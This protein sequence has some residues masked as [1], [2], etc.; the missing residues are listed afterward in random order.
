MEFLA[1]LPR[2]PDG[3]VARWRLRKKLV[4]VFTPP[5]GMSPP[6]GITPERL[7]RFV[8]KKEPGGPED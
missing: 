2:D 8:E 1:Q 7:L 5:S 3:K 6:K 4:Q